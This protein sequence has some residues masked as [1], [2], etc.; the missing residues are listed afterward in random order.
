[1]LAKRVVYSCQALTLVESRQSREVAAVLNLIFAANA[2]CSFS[3]MPDDRIRSKDEVEQLLQLPCFGEIPPASTPGK[4]TPPLCQH[5][6]RNS[7]GS[8]ILTATIEV[9]IVQ[10][11]L[12]KG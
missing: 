6:S 2:T 11:V 12:A 8:K 3:E 1:M 9:I 7:F 5:P 10:A 4:N